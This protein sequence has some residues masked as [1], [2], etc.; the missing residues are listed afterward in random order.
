[1]SELP[2]LPPAPRRT[3]PLPPGG[4]DGAL[5]EGRRR[6]TRFLGATGG[7]ATAAV[8][9][10][11]LVAAGPSSQQS[12]QY[13]DDPTPSAAPE[14]SAQPSPGATASPDAGPAPYGSP[15][16]Q[17]SP[18]PDA[19]APGQT[20]PSPDGNAPAPAA[21]APDERDGFTESP[22]ERAAP[23]TCRQPPTGSAGPVFYGGGS[24][25]VSGETS[26][27]RVKRGGRVSG[28]IDICEPHGAGGARLGYDGGQEHE[29][30]VTRADG[31][32]VYRFSDTVRYEQGEHVRVLGDGRCLVW[33]GAWDTTLADGSL[34][35][36]GS[37][38]VRVSVRP[39]TI[40]GRR[41][42]P[43]QTGA[44]EFSVYVEE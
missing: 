20:A 39:D 22:A 13:A 12:L 7:V 1:M 28:S 5:R 17:P 42:T 37:Y 32:V 30:T 43:E 10:L 21:E 40:D 41:T 25:C 31:R 44:V 15:E 23:A 27:S 16:A 38:Q 36:A 3:R 26:D 29:V 14:Q 4:L 8:L 34:A 6:R 35:P 11:A 19:Q 9:V 33:T 18:T 24:A 2:D